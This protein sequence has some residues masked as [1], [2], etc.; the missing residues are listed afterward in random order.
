M[1]ASTFLM[2]FKKQLWVIQ[3][4]FFTDGHLLCDN[5]W[6]DLWLKEKA[7]PPTATKQLAWSLF[8]SFSFCV[9]MNNQGVWLKWHIIPLTWS[10]YFTTWR[11]LS[12]M[13]VNCSFG[14]PICTKDMVKSFNVIRLMASSPCGRSALCDVSRS[15]N[16]CV[17]SRAVLQ[18][19]SID[20]MNPA[21]DYTY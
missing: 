18:N 20:C 3:G 9:P 21:I 15:A 12:Q 6:C 17:F 8:L 19:E 16:Q 1:H 5:R 10:Y 2:C 13:R 7:F 4:H 14:D 11:W